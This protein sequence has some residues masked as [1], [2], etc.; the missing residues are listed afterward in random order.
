VNPTTSS[1]NYVAH[2]VSAANMTVVKI[3][4]NGQVCFK[5]F[6]NTDLIVDLSGW[7]K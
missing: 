7:F 1:V 5:S 2:Q 6:A 3:P 4:A